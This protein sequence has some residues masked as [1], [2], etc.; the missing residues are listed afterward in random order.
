[1][2]S[3]LPEVLPVAEVV[4]ALERC[5]DAGVSS[6]RDD[7]LD[8]F[9]VECGWF[10][11]ELDELVAGYGCRSTRMTRLSYRGVS[12]VGLRWLEPLWPGVDGFRTVASTRRRSSA[13]CSAGNRRMSPL[14]DER[15]LS[16][17]GGRPDSVL[18][19]ELVLTSGLLLL[20]V[21]V[22]AACAWVNWGGAA[23]EVA[24]GAIPSGNGAL[25]S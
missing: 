5:H 25:S 19:L 14:D 20:A 1:M 24:A 16:H 22:L 2:A 12:V 9:A 17:D 13:C 3:A 15:A 4:P 18:E 8:E 11:D 21:V 10:D 6:T 23:F 7:E